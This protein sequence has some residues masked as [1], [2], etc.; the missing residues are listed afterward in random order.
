[1]RT[2]T[3]KKT[4]NF[5]E[6]KWKVDLEANHAKNLQIFFSLLLKA[7]ICYPWYFLSFVCFTRSRSFT[8][9]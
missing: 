5:H 7:T 3:D 2:H 9:K 8:I 6:H 1:M 4:K